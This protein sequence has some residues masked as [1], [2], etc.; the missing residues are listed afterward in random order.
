MSIVN[1]DQGNSLIWKFSIIQI[2]VLFIIGALLFLL[3]RE[4]IDFA[5]G[6]WNSPEYSHAYL[7]PFISLFILWQNYSNIRRTEFFGSWLGV[8]LLIAGLLFLL[9]GEFST[10]Y[11]V[12]QYSFLIVFGWFSSISFRRVKFVSIC[13]PHI[14][15]IFYYSITCIFI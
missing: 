11:T 7:I 6:K 14:F 12:I 15:I 13:H 3:Y 5:V 8:F 4:G 10:L 2:G 1:S 9:I